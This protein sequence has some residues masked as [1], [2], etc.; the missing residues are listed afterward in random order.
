MLRREQQKLK[1]ALHLGKRDA[2][3][4]VSE[5][6]DLSR[7]VED[8]ELITPA[9]ERELSE[10]TGKKQV[11]MVEENLL[12]LRQKQARDRLLSQEA[13]TVTLETLRQLVEEGFK[14]RGVE[15]DLQKEVIQ[16]QL[17]QATQCCQKIRAEVKERLR[18]AQKLKKK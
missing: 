2:E 8:L 10:V 9:M 15:L 4:V 6:R 13:G 3:K 17:R 7:K 14:E 16:A 11:S 12:K 1:G 5:R 18:K